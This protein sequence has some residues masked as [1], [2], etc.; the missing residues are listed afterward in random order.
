[1]VSKL[2]FSSLPPPATTPSSRVDDL[3]DNDNNN[4][5]KAFYSQAIWGSLELKPNENHKSRFK[6]MDSFFSMHSYSR[7]NPWV[8]SI[9][10]SFLFIASSHINFGLPLSLFTFLSCLRIPPHTGVSRGLCWTCLRACLV[11]L[12]SEELI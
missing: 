9:L 12:F 11:Q 8:Y 10:L 5:N 2:G 7:L 6:H 4:N 1:M 3:F